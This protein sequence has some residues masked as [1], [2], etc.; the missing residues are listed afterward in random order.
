MLSTKS[1]AQTIV[2]TPYY[3]SPEMCEG[4]EYDEKSDIWALGCILYEMAALKR[5]FN[6][7]NLSLLVQKIVRCEYEDIPYCYAKDIQTLVELILQKNIA[8]RPSAKYIHNTIIPDIMAK[9]NIKFDYAQ[10][11]ESNGKNLRYNKRSV[12]YEITH[13]DVEF[14]VAPIILPHKRIVDFSVSSTHSIVI[15]EDHSIYSWG[16]NKYCEL[17]ANTADILVGQPIHIKTLEHKNI[18]KCATGKNFS[19]FLTK[20]GQLY[21]CGHGATG[22]LGH[23][24]L[25]NAYYPILIRSLSNNIIKDV[26]CGSK[27]VIALD[28]QGKIYVWG[29][30][31]FGQ[32]GLKNTGKICCIPVNLQIPEEIKNIFC[33]DDSTILLSVQNSVF[34]SGHNIYEKLGIPNNDRTEIIQDFKKVKHNFGI[35]AQISMSETH[36]TLINTEGTVF[37][38]GDNTYGQLGKV[39]GI[40]SKFKNCIRLDNKLLHGACANTFTTVFD[41]KNI[42]WFWGSIKS[43]K[44]TNKGTQSR[45]NS[46]KNH[47]ILSLHQ[48][49]EYFT[50]KVRVSDTEDDVEVDRVEEIRSILALYS[51]QEN[52]QSGNYIKMINVKATKSSILLL[53]DTTCPAPYKRFTEPYNLNN[54][55]KM[56]QAKTKTYYNT[57]ET[58]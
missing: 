35:V 45:S 43:T 16:S 42:L 31:K 2:G 36:T 56:S 55:S 25:T 6:A 14:N 38:F 30:P 20:H 4:R 26:I 9:N 11:T 34:V 21:S 48:P 7:P 32:H 44:N 12:L 15:F 40:Y 33:S 47:T 51:S 54:L 3:L 41:E 52:I 19:I 28:M 49:E 18:N 13:N 5:P 46:L 57:S 29:S 27:H 8:F 1:Q 58:Q 23:G 22:C 24:N 10:N 17:G 50:A 37:L 53:V 39:T